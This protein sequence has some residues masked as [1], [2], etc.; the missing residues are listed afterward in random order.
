MDTNSFT[1]FVPTYFSNNF[2]RA[3]GSPAGINQ[4]YHLICL[5]QINFQ[6]KS[7]S[8]NQFLCPLPALT[9]INDGASC[10]AWTINSTNLL[11]LDKQRIDS[12]LS[13]VYPEYGLTSENTVL[14]IIGSNFVQIEGLQCV[15]GDTVCS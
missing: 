13:D 7:L 9:T 6:G 10:K 8:G 5:I 3:F 1:G 15:I 2:T 12:N 14:T 4:Q 11:F